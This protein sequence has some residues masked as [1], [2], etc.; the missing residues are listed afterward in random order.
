MN[1]FLVIVWV[2]FSSAALGQSVT[3]KVI[4]AQTAVPIPFA[5]VHLIDIQSGTLTNEQGVFEFKNTLPKQIRIKIS[6]IGY[7]TIIKQIQLPV[8]DTL[9]FQLNEMHV[10]LAEVT[11]STPTGILQKHT[12]ANVE[13]RSLTELNTISNTNLGEAIS[14]IPGVYQISTGS[15]ISKPVIRGLSGIRV[16]TYLNGLRI[17]NQQWGGD[18]GMGVSEI[19]IGNVEVIKGPSSLLY[20]ADALGGVVYFT[21]ENFAK[22][23]TNEGYVETQFESVSMR[24][25]NFVAYKS[26]K[27]NLRFNLFGNFSSNSDYMLPNGNFVKNSRFGEANLKGALGYNKKNWILNVR[28]NLMYNQTGLPGHTHDSIIK[29]EIF[30]SEKPKRSFSIPLQQTLNN[31]LLTE[32]IFYLKNS[33]L[34]INLGISNNTLQEFEEKVTIPGIYMSLSNYNYNAVWRKSI[35]DKIDWLIGAQGMFQTNRNNK[36]ATEQLL[37]NANL[38]DNGVYTLLHSTFNKYEF[39]TGVRVDNRQIQTLQDFKGNQVLNRQFSGFN[40]SAGLTR[41]LNKFLLRANVST[42]FRPPH[43]SELLSNGVHHGTL[44]YE[45]GNRD[46]KSEQATQFDFSTEYKTDHISL[47]V[48]P[49]YNQINNYIYISPQGVLKNGYPLFLYSQVAKA[50]L[51]GTD[52]GLHYH[53]HFAHNLHIEPSFSFIQAEDENRNPLALIPQTRFN[54]QIRYEFD[55]K[56]GK[57]RFQNI[58]FQHLYFLHQ[59]RVAAF[60]TNSPAYQLINIGANL[61]VETKNPIFVKFG[62]RNLLNTNYIDHLSRIKNIGLQSPGIN[63]YLTLKWM[64]N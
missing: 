6:A 38:V 2:L 54:T 3:G 27:N 47:I 39:Q 49:F 61:K 28:Y 22:Q 58:A 62:I 20:G 51:V 37:P 36:I 15:G 17:E 50:T 7:E 25:K 46:L 4:D 52:I 21:D 8:Q 9:I 14:N 56:K 59:D 33:D 24:T 26:A 31:Y 42:G 45:I 19:G 41:E 64:F 1:K 10:E 29:P 53:P 34:K 32:N 13:S 63:F 55:G 30:Q 11:I 5:N 60:E 57:I 23:N 43:L 44:R 40:Y 18:H 48:N 12:I 35:T 16:V